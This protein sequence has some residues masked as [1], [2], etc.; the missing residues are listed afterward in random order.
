[1]SKKST[2]VNSKKTSTKDQIKALTKISGAITSDLLLDDILK[3]IVVVTAKI[4]RSS[5]CSIQ[6]VDE[7]TGGLIIRATQSMSEEYNKKP[8]LKIGEGIAGKVVL[9]KKPVAIKDITL[10]NEYKYRDIAKKE[11]LC[12]LLCLPLNVKN[13][14]IGVLNVYTEK[15]HVFTG[16]EIDLLTSIANQAAIAI[17]NAE[18]VVKSKVVQEELETRKFFERAKGILMRDEDLTE[19]EAYLKIQKFAMDNRKPIREISEAIILSA[20]LKKK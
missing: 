14:V 1:M 8:P 15:P 4:M 13:N 2:Y 5:I 10:E 3:L 7:K 18:L 17:E 20:D 19:E 6:L 11:G 9:S 12:S 16:T